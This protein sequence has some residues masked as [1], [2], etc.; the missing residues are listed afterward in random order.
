MSRLNHFFSRNKRVIVVILC[1]LILGFLL[2]YSRTEREK[3]TPVE[4]VVRDVFSPVN[5]FFSMIGNKISSGFDFVVSIGNMKDENEDLKKRVDELAMEN[6]RLENAARE[7]ERLLAIL[8]LRDMYQGETEAARIVYRDPSNWLGTFMID[9][10]RNSGVEDGMAVICPGGLVGRIISTSDS[11]S[12]VMQIIDSRSSVGGINLRTNDPVIVDGSSDGTHTCLA[13]PLT[14]S[15][16]FQIG[17]VIVSSGTGGVFPKGHLIGE[18]THVD[19]GKY[20]VSYVATVQ[21]KVDFVRL[22][23][24]LILLEKQPGTDHLDI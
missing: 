6:M 4:S 8:E 1:V 5:N 3:I 17:D 20:G 22:E 7:N 9:K 23:E 12:T 10:G 16:D 13:R 14:A 11:T 21:P 19:E 24:V 2:V 15:A 18:V